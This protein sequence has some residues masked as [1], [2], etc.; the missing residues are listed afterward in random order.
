[1]TC[2]RHQQPVPAKKISKKRQWLKYKQWKCKLHGGGYA[3]LNKMRVEHK[4]PT[5][6]ELME[7]SVDKFIILVANYCG[8]ESRTKELIVNWV[9]SLFLK[10]H[11]EASKEDKPNWTETTNGPFDD[12]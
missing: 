12:G 5:V 7:I 9:H 2:G 10:A 3:A 11:A 6:D 4:I 8:C 1:M